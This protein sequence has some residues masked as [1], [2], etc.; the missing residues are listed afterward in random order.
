MKTL[1]LQNQNDV[2]TDG[3]TTMANKISPFRHT[4]NHKT[5][6]LRTAVA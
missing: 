3:Q 1:E 5:A 6:D 4:G 2:V